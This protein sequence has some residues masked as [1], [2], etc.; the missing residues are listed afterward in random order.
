M[1][2]EFRDMKTQKG[3]ELKLTSP[4]KLQKKRIK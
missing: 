1:S 2:K 4:K 3:F